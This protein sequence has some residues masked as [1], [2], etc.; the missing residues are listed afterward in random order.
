MFPQAQLLTLVALTVA[1]LNARAAVVHYPPIQS[2]INNLT[3]VLTGTGAPGIYNSSTTPDALYGEYNWCNMPHVRPREYKTPSKDYSL[4]YVEVIH[5][6]HKRTPYSSNTFFKEDIPWNCTGEGPV[7]YGKGPGGVSAQV[8]EIQWAGFTDAQNPFISTVGPGFVGSDCQ[9]PQITEGGLVDSHT[10]GADLRAVYGSRLKLKEKLDPDV[11]KVRVTNNVITSQVAGSLLN[12]LFPSTDNVAVE[13]QSGTY[14]SLEPTY[15][16]PTANNVKNGYMNSANWTGHLSA[17]APLYAKLDQVSGTSNP[18]N[19]GWHSSFDHYYDNLSAKLCHQ[20]TLPCSVNDTASC[21]TQD[22]ADEVF[23][24]GNW[25]YSY[26]YR[27]APGT[28]QYSALH[29]GAWVLELQSH[30]QGVISGKSKLRYVHNVAHDGSV[31]SLLGFLQIDKMVWPGMGSEVVFELYEKQNAYYLRVLWGGQP[32][33]T[34]TPLGTL[35]LIPVQEFYDYVQSM[36]G[37]STDLL[38]N[39]FS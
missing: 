38:A 3:F 1:A 27:D 6:H 24:L 39:C 26:Q 5:R 15:S 29:Y 11:V 33:V 4:K 7:V 10:H 31:S 23:R 16:C 35:D 25:E 21:V 30:L 17:A 28:A 37:T 12:A 34:S 32:M 20:K 2:N 9:L 18:D 19:G 8:S 22:E 13:I 14:D 36:V